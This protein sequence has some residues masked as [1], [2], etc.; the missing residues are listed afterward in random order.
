VLGVALGVGGIVHLLGDMLT[1]HGCP[2][3]WPIP[4]GRRMWR[5]IGVP[6]RIAVTVG[7]KVEVLVYRTIF[8]LIAV[9]AGTG[10][11]AKPFLRRYD[12]EV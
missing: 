12:I 1:S 2:V 11:F 7:G 6:D 10:L 9:A 8:I 3:L 4:T 5:C